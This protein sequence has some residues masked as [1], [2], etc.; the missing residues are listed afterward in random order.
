MQ[1]LKMIVLSDRVIW[2][3]PFCLFLMYGIS[4]EK[5]EYSEVQTQKSFSQ[6]VVARKSR[7]DGRR[8]TL[9]EVAFCVVTSGR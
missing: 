1:Y 3:E 2:L 9:A 5:L 8:S 6:Q 7:D 4:F